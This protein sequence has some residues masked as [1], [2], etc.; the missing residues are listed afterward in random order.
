MST[1][2]SETAAAVKASP[3]SMMLLKVS[4]MQ[5]AGIRLCLPVQALTGQLR[6]KVQRSGPG[7]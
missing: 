6:R 4:E 1:Q 7:A 2:L 5:R 3:T